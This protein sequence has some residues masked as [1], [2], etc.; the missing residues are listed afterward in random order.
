[1]DF[2][3]THIPEYCI[4][5]FIS[6]LSVMA[7][8]FISL[9][10]RKLNNVF[11]IYSNYLCKYDLK[12]NLLL[13]LHNITNY[14]WFYNSMSLGFIN[15]DALDHFFNHQYLFPLIFFLYPFCVVRLWIYAYPCYFPL[16]SQ[17]L[18]VQQSSFR[19]K[20]TIIKYAPFLSILLMFCWDRFVA[21]NKIIL[22]EMNNISKPFIIT[23][24]EDSITTT[25]L[26]SI[27]I[28]YNGRNL[29]LHNTNFKYQL[30]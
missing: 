10:C 28:C 5:D 18:S 15:F 11:N 8:D 20:S 4:H 12:C 17:Y 6:V 23:A 7:Q 30:K 1:M 19:V 3:T 9:R 26:Y 13:I 29:R 16:I 14:F 21:D 2:A 27:G 22:K 25:Y 24:F